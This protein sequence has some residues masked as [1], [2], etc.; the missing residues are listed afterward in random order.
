MD[1]SLSQHAPL[2]WGYSGNT[3]AS[4]SWQPVSRGS[5]RPLSESDCDDVYSEESSKEQCTSP[6]DADSCQMLSRKKRRGVIE[7][8]RRDRINMSLSELKRLVPSAFEKQGSAKLEKA[9][10]LQMTVD[11]LKMLHAKGL[12]SFAY[13]PHKYAMDYHGMGFRE[14]VAEVARYLERIE[15]L[16]VQNP[17]RLRLTSHLQCCAAQRELASK[18]A[19]A[20]PWTYPGS[21]PPYT[22]LPPSPASNH[23][24][25][26]NLN[27]HQT[28]PP[29]PPPPQNLHELSHYDVSTSCAQTTVPVATTDNSR[30][31]PSSS[32]LTPLTATT[33][34]VLSYSSHQYPGNAFSI[35]SAHHHQNY[36]QNVPTSQGMKPYRPWGA[37]VA[38]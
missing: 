11:H 8:K 16:D 12:D 37:E 9:E 17:L 36:G 14:C 18:Q 31:P 22:P 26:P 2:Q 29:P 21:Q 19:T 5:K 33:P 7:K 10:I 1:H 23:G 3:S 27:H 15:G 34:S 13:D 32:I 25:L 30:L 20:G 6:G 4:S 38:Y 35:P 28:P 24:H